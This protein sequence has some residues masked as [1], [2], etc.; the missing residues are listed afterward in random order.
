L[1]DHPGLRPPLLIEEGSSILCH[2]S[3]PNKH[4]GRSISAPLLDEEGW[5]KAGVVGA[6]SK[7]THY[8]PGR[9]D[10]R[11]DV[12]LEAQREGS[13]TFSACFRGAR[14]FIA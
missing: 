10:A 5:P 9:R 2:R 8:P 14:G 3:P 6:V 4:L 1:V 13:Q 7:L 12:S 11:E